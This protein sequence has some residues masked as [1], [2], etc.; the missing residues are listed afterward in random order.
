[1]MQK[2]QQQQ[3]KNDAHKLKIMEVH[4]FTSIYDPF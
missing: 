4:Q 2:L 3:T 1:M